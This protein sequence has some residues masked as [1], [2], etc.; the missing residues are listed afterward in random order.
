MNDVHVMV[1]E[2]LYLY[3]RSIDD[4]FMVKR[5]LRPAGIEPA[6]RNGPAERYVLSR[7][8]ERSE[9]QME[10]RLRRRRA[11]LASIAPAL[12]APSDIGP[13]SESE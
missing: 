5:V 1:T 13:P 7:A 3:S 11:V 12:N 10:R 4:S 6:R 2:Q 9:R 8:F